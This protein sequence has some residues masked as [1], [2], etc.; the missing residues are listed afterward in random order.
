MVL[1]VPSGR[2]PDLLAPR[3]LLARRMERSKG[4]YLRKEATHAT[5]TVEK[6]CEKTRELALSG[7]Q[8]YIMVLRGRMSTDPWAIC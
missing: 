8:D 1:G 4:P 6:F 5:T 2:E 7:R 3:D